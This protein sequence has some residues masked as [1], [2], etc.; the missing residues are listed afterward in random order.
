M[1]QRGF[2]KERAD[3]LR[4]SNSSPESILPL[5]Q[6]PNM[7]TICQAKQDP[8]GNKVLNAVVRSRAQDVKYIALAAVY[9]RGEE[10]QTAEQE[11]ESCYDDREAEGET[12]AQEEF[13]ACASVEGVGCGVLAREEV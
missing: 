8:R 12:L 13:G 3:G 2:G 1:V 11:V 7:H 9:Y 4:L 5:Q 10:E 6:T